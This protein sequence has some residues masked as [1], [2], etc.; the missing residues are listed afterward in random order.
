MKNLMIFTFVLLL[1]ANCSPDEN[2]SAT[3]KVVNPYDITLDKI[4]GSDV[5]TEIK[6][7][8][9]TASGKE[10]KHV[11]E[12]TL[13]SEYY[14]TIEGDTKAFYRL[15]L[16]GGFEVVQNLNDPNLSSKTAKYIIRPIDEIANGLALSV[17]VI[18]ESNGQLLREAPKRSIILE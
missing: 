11:S 4:G 7:Q 3:T 8:V 2:S 15:G 6:L 17:I 13:G 12:L 9:T 18:H 1:A 14:L 5:Q 10:I 16:K